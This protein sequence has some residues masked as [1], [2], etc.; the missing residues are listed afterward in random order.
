MD[1]FAH[2]MWS[3]AIFHKKRYVW[4][5][6]LFGLLPDFL[7]FGIVF[8][9]NLFNGNFHR[10]PPPINSVPEWLFAAYNMTHSLV[11]FIAVFLLV[12]L[13]IKK[14][15]WPLTAWGIH[16]ITDIPTHSARYF[17][18]PFLWPL[19]DYTFNGIGWGTSWFMLLNYSALMLVFIMIA[20]NRAME[21]KSLK[22][23]KK[24]LT[25]GY[26]K[27]KA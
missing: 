12:Y 8:V 24:S 11:M 19:S 25:H 23:G 4:L 5:A 21:R 20:C 27:A 3:C 16:I 7:S 13:L 6:A 14:W 10:G 18:T 9:M 26:R 22:N 17:P 1:I 2:G 15:F